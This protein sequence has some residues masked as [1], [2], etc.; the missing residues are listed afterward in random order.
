MASQG[1]HP[2]S[3]QLGAAL[4]RGRRDSTP[5]LP[6]CALLVPGGAEAVNQGT[7][8]PPSPRA[9]AP[10]PERRRRAE[11]RWVLETGSSRFRVA[12]CGLL[13]GTACPGHNG[14]LPRT[15]SSG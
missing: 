9:L 7:A 3:G 13:L 8:P 4:G 1:Y 11:G 12:G 15:R 2:S 6:A 10:C 5:G 14:Y